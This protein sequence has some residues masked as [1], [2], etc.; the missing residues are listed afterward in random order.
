MSSLRLK[1]TIYKYLGVYLAEKEEN[2]YLQSK[3]FWKSW[4]KQMAHPENDMS[5]RNVQGLMIG[6]WQADHGFTRPMS[7]LSLRSYKYRKFWYFLGWFDCL[8]L[9]IKWD[10]EKLFRKVRK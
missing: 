1:S 5:P 6:I 3:E 8:F 2:D 7:R 9:T 10:L 4:S